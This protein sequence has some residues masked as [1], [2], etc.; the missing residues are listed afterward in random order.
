MTDEPLT[1]LPC[2]FC[3]N[4]AKFDIL[5]KYDS[6]PYGSGSRYFE[7]RVICPACEI[8]TKIY[9]EGKQEQAIAAWNRRVEPFGNP[10][11]LPV[12]AREEIEQKYAFVS[13]DVQEG[14]NEGYM[15]ALKWVL[16]LRKPEEPC[17]Q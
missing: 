6:G 4:P 7:Y 1:L 17:T 12:W 3:D 10:D 14:F 2:P 15:Y 11:E 5:T 16:S 13:H 9:D 8:S